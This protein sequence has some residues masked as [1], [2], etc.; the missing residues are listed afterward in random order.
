MVKQRKRNPHS[1]QDIIL[2]SNFANSYW[3]EELCSVCQK[4]KFFNNFTMTF[5][6]EIINWLIDRRQLIFVT[7]VIRSLYLANKKQFPKT[8]NLADLLI[9]CY[10]FSI[11]K[12]H[13]VFQLATVN[14]IVRFYANFILIQPQNF[15]ILYVI[16]LK[17][18]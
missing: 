3:L 10:R 14:E 4:C 6:F 5:N 18:K 2:W 15:N 11:C 7:Q 17:S 16:H 13:F 9:D 8:L 12:F 1:R